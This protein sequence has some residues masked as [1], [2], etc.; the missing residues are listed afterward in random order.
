MCSSSGSGFCWPGGGQV[1]DARAIVARMRRRIEEGQSA[2]D[3]DGC[4]SPRFL[5]NTIIEEATAPI[6]LILNWKPKEPTR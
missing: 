6:T 2:R 3:V 5:M 1:S 4:R